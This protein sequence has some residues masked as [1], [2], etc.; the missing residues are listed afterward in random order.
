MPLLAHAIRPYHPNVG[1]N[2]LR[3][4]VAKVTDTVATTTGGLQ[5]DRTV[6]LGH[7]LTMAT[8]AVGMMFGY[9]A[10][11]ETV[12]NHEMRLKYL[13]T[14]IQAQVQ[15]HNDLSARMSNV[16]GEL[17]NRMSGVASDV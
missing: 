10:Y 16:A 2:R 8:M 4:W 5:F 7:V 6:S 3:G 11:K 13:E 12:V 15:S 14:Q 17:S 1:L 9:S